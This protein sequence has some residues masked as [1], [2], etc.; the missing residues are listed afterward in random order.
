MWSITTEDADELHLLSLELGAIIYLRS[1]MQMDI[2]DKLGCA[3]GLEFAQKHSEYYLF[4]REY[5]CVKKLRSIIEKRDFLKEK[6]APS[7]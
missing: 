6:Q 7:D 5:E 1:L 3:N 4:E 2:N